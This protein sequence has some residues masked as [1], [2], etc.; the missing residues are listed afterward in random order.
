VFTPLS[1]VTLMERLAENELLNFACAQFHDTERYQYEFAVS[2]LHCTDR[3]AII[4]SWADQR[5]R[6]LAQASQVDNNA[7]KDNQN[8]KDNK[9]EPSLAAA[10]IGLAKAVVRDRWNTPSRIA[11]Y[12]RTSVLRHNNQF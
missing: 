12:L 6:L 1:F 3:A 5:Q 8:I 9:E 7:K 2:L 10:L 4:K 11:S